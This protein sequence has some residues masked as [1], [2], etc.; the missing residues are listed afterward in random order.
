[1]DGWKTSFPFRM[2]YFHVRLLLVSREGIS[3]IILSTC[4]IIFLGP[5]GIGIKA[6]A[7][8]REER[9]GHEVRRIHLGDTWLTSVQGGPVMYKTCPKAWDRNYRNGAGFFS[10]KENPALDVLKIDKFLTYL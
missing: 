7:A 2:A 1:M 5:R 8:N 9:M 4:F 6:G 10:T 3:F